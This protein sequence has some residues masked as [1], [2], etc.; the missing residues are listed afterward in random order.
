[1][2]QSRGIKGKYKGGKSYFGHDTPTLLVAN[3]S[4]RAFTAL[5]ILIPHPFPSIFFKKNSPSLRRSKA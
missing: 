4:I 5:F 1:M 3:S 2:K